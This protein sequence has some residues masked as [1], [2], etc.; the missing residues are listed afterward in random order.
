M[1]VLLSKA[2][3]RSAIQQSSQENI[4]SIDTVQ[5]LYEINLE[6][7]EGSLNYIENIN[8]LGLEEQNIKNNVNLQKIDKE[9]K[10]YI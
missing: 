6:T 5:K 9:T 8:Y 3:I 1:R 4:D 10:E 2:E 7:I